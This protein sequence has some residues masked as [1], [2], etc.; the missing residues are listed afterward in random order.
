MLRFLENDI[1]IHFAR[2]NETSYAV[3]TLQD[4]K[5]VEKIIKK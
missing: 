5:K 3:D 2:T 4:L 1:G